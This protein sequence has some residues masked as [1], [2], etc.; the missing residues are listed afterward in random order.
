MKNKELEKIYNSPFLDDTAKS[1]YIND[2]E[3]YLQ[4]T[5]E[6]KENKIDELKEKR[7][8]L[9]L[10]NFFSQNQITSALMA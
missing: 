4:E 8:S 2:R 7:E 10:G 6:K 1:K 3:K 9:G 5:L